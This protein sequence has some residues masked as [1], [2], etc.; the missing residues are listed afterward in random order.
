MKSHGD[1]DTYENA[2][3]VLIKSEIAGF[4]PTGEYPFI[5]ICLASIKTCFYTGFYMFYTGVS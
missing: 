4:R 2:L 1:H 5:I 3:W